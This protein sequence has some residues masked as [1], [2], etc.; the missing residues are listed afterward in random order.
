MNRGLSKSNLP[1]W[2][3]LRAACAALICACLALAQPAHA[4]TRSVATATGTAQAAIIE[5][6]TLFATQP[7][8]FGRIAPRATS[9]TVVLEPTNGTCSV[10]GTIL[11]FDRCQAGE[12]V[13]MGRRRFIVR[14]SLPAS[15]TLTGPGGTIVL[16]TL[17]LDTSPD[18]ALQGGNGNGNAPKRYEIVSPTG[19]YA[20]TVGG[21]LRVGANQPAGTYTGTYAVTAIYQ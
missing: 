10:T 11:Q 13:G 21:T 16:D 18:L 15:V 12:F 1:N 14:I 19:I 6:N 7:M 3:A 4:Q 17:T 8:D 5:T 9:G 2:Q 20:F